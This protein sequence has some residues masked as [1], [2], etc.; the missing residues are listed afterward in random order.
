M[1]VCSDAVS[2]GYLVEDEGSFARQNFD[3]SSDNHVSQSA[4]EFKKEKGS[5]SA[6][7]V[8]ATGF[9]DELAVLVF[10]RSTEVVTLDLNVEVELHAGG[11]TVLE[12]RKPLAIVLTD[13][14]VD[15]SPVTNRLGTITPLAA[16]LGAGALG[17]YIVLS[18]GDLA[19]PLEVG[20]AVRASQGLKLIVAKGQ[21]DGLRFGTY[22]QR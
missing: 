21:R 16:L 11:G 2:S 9:R 22:T 6:T 13:T 8:I 7:R 5:Y 14:E 1:P 18:G 15:G 12:D 17:V 3:L 19:L 10:T 20:F 4:F